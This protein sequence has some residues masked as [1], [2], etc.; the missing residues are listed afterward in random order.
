MRN[1]VILG[2]GRISLSNEGLLLR[3]GN[4]SHFDTQSEDFAKYSILVFIPLMLIPG[5]RPKKNSN[6]FIGP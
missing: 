5:I 4:V 1:D 3:D 6:Q 2:L